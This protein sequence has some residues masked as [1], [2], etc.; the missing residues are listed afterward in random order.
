MYK[1]LFLLILTFNAYAGPQYEC[2]LQNAYNEARGEG[3]LGVELVTSVV[4]N[5]AEMDDKTACEVIY[6]PKQ[7]SWVP[8][9]LVAPKEFKKKYIKLVKRVYKKRKK[10]YSKLYFFHAK[11]IKPY[12]S[13]QARYKLSYR[14]HVFYERQP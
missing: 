9:P 13:P 4:M 12:Q 10:R 2:L 14:G 3:E 6:T 5:R 1:M 7:F 8:S 11:R